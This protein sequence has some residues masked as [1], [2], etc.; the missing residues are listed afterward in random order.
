MIRSRSRCDRNIP[1]RGTE[2]TQVTKTKAPAKT[3]A[4]PKAP[5]KAKPA[6][7][8]DTLFYAT[9]LGDAL[10]G[11]Y[12]A[13]IQRFYV[14][15]AKYHL[16]QKTVFPRARNASEPLLKPEDAVAFLKKHEV[17]SIPAGSKTGQ[18]LFD[19][20]MVQSGAR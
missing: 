11:K 10:A 17:T 1:D 4:K 6:A 13:Q 15:A 3:A 2:M 8:T 9:L 19:E 16:T 7:K 12:G 20:M 5:A 18:R 14:N